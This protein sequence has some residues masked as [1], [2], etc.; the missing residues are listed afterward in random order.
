MLP[1]RTHETFP[2]DKYPWFE[3]ITYFSRG[4]GAAR[5]GD[6]QTA[7]NNLSRLKEL[8]DQTMHAEQNYWATLVDSQRKSVESWIMF[9]Q[10]QKMNALDLM[11][12]AADLE[13]SVDKHP[14]TPGA[15]LPARELLGDMLIELERYEDSIA[16]YK[17]ALEVSANRLRSLTGIKTAEQL[18]STQKTADTRVVGTALVAA[19]GN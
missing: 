18:S 17:R 19:S 1:I 13:D 8:Y 12:K 11:T 14:V 10:G 9:S 2:W 3:A 7:N 4:I 6:I 15:V 5:S 16:A